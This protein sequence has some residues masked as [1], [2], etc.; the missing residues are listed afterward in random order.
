ME[1]LRPRFNLAFVSTNKLR[2]GTVRKLK[3]ELK[4]EVKRARGDLVVKSSRS[5]V[6][7]RG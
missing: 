5:Y 7:P 6:A 4:P 2:D 1:H 3:I